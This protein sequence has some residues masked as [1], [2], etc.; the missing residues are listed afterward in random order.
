LGSGRERC[1]GRSLRV[2][3]GREERREGERTEE[4]EEAMK[5]QN[6]VARRNHK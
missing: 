6:Q 2:R 1:E 4:K 3:A 5:G